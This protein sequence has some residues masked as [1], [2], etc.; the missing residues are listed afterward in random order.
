MYLHI[1]I[2]W[3]NYVGKRPGHSDNLAAGS[4]YWLAV[5][6]LLLISEALDQ[7]GERITN[8]TTKLKH[9][10]GERSRHSKHVIVE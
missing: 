6:S 10:L 2:A 5:L 7:E 9:C 8:A 4:K 1:H 3:A